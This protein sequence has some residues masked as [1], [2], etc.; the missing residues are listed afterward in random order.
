MRLQ[1]MI[2]KALDANPDAA[3]T[4]LHDGVAIVFTDKEGTVHSLKIAM[5]E[6]R[7]KEICV[8]IANSDQPRIIST[9]LA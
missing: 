9:K 6:D 8:A 4:M 5:T 7:L 2:Q 3:G 1:R